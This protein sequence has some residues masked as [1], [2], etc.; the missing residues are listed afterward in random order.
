MLVFKNVIVKKSWTKSKPKNHLDKLGTLNLYVCIVKAIII[1][2][3]PFC[4]DECNTI[5][6]LGLVLTCVS[7]FPQKISLGSGIYNILGYSNAT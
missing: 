6:S 3:I 1:L 4:Y 2:L 7:S 5:L